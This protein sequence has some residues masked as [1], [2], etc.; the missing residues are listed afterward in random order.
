MVDIEGHLTGIDILPKLIADQT[1]RRAAA[2]D[3]V[4]LDDEG[5]VDRMSFEEGAVV[6]AQVGDLVCPISVGPQFGVVARNAQVV[7]DDEIVLYRAADTNPSRMVPV[8]EGSRTADGLSSR[9][10]ATGDPWWPAEMTAPG[11]L[12]GSAKRRTL[13]RPTL[14]TCT[15]R[16]SICVARAALVLESP[17]VD[18]DTQDRVMPGDPGIVD[19]HFTRRIPPDVVVPV[20]GQLRGV[21]FCLENAFR[22]RGRLRPLSHKQNA[23]EPSPSAQVRDVGP[24]RRALSR[25]KQT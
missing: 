21:T 18:F 16:P 13:L 3:D 2:A 6:A 23:T 25:T 19:S 11:P 5:L 17:G 20:R 7:V 14:H 12:L 1:E 22:C 4:S 8:E 10:V 9:P 24:S 15:Q